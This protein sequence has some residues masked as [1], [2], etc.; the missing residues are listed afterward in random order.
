MTE[1][2]TK[3][4]R[5]AIYT[6]KSRE[7]GL[8]QSFNSLH[9]QR[10]AAENYI[11]SQVHEG[12]V[13][14]PEYY[15]DGA[16]SGGNIDRPA[17]Q[18][19]MEDIKNNKIDCV[20]VYKVER[21]CRSNSDFVRIIEIF[22]KH[23]VN[24]VS[25]T[26]SFNT[27]TASGR[28]MLGMLINFAQYERELCSERI[29]D[30]FANSKKKGIWMGGPI[31]LGYNLND[32]NLLI[33][34]E[35]SRIVISI[36]NQFIKT[37]SITQIVRNLN[38]SGITTKK[39]ISKKGRIYKGTK[40]NK[41]A[42]ERILKSPLYI[43]KITHKNSVYEGQHK[44]IISEE[45]FNMVQEIFKKGRREK[46]VMPISRI[47]MPPLLK[48]IIR[49][50][51]CS[52]NMS[53]SYTAKKNKKYRYY[54]CSRKLRRGDKECQV[55]SISASQLEELVKSQILQL[56]KKPE[57]IIYTISAS[58][59]KE[60]SENEIINYFQNIEKIWDELF[61][62]EQVRIINL[63]MQQIIVCEDRVDL[64]IFKKGLI[65]LASEIT[66]TQTDE[67]NEGFKN[68]KVYDEIITI[69][70]PIKLRKKKGYITLIL[71]NNDASL[72][73]DKISENH[74]GK[75]INAFS[76]AYKWQ[77]MIRNKKAESLSEIARIERTDKAYIAKIF[78]LNYVAPDIIR[79]I[80]DG[81]QPE[82]LKLRDFTHSAI[83]DLWEEQR[84]LYGFKYKPKTIPVN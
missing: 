46:V 78:K 30:K 54:I 84:E 17:F 16:Y 5:C 60:I 67:E 31:P 10:F 51:C 27:G 37:E 29:R 59:S 47:S 28:L 68:S 43:G 58:S 19:M 24:F 2:T 7:E 1:M 15:D 50:G 77:Q 36:Y 8:E 4:I 49:C 35:E 13:L 76:N 6:R 40:F 23:N 83:P 56:L 69:S 32:R 33:N 18:R 22:D 9:A 25:V 26:E 70:V 82:N 41:I 81:K 80:L 20:V 53:P 14:N 52:C 55:G 65:S 64:R 75:L 45:V 3:K 73:K 48:S 39:W 79:T 21:M 34:E 44:G 74:N 11:A 42:V 71:S 72:E 63:L 12:W 62:V 57:I 61:P 66:T 38:Q